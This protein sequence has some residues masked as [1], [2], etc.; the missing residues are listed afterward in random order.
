[1]RLLDYIKN[2]YELYRRF[3]EFFLK[4]PID[5][6]NLDTCV[7]KKDLVKLLIVVYS[8]LLGFSPHFLDILK[9]TERVFYG[10][11]ISFL[12]IAI[13]YYI[14]IQKEKS[15]NNPKE[16]KYY[17]FIIFIFVIAFLL[18]MTF[19]LFLTAFFLIG[20]IPPESAAVTTDTILNTYTL[21]TF[22]MLA[23]LM[24]KDKWTVA[25][26]YIILFVFYFGFS[27]YLKGLHH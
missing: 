1:M 20:T 3:F 8:I 23:A 19:S 14:T 7:Q 12:F 16:I 24:K 15:Y 27:Y 6:I 21:A 22:G 11:G 9:G 18:S 4:A 26:F 25:L 2:G 10:T 17:L 13:L 5:F